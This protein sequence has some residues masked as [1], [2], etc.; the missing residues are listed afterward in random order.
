MG[1]VAS[2]DEVHR[3]RCGKQRATSDSKPRL[4]STCTL[5]SQSSPAHV[6]NEDAADNDEVEL[7]EACELH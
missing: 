3:C 5:P 1:H 4:R 7:D 6:Y 2:V